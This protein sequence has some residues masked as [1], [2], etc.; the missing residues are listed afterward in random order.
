MGL[1]KH[2][3]QWDGN[4]VWKSSEMKWVSWVRG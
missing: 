3:G 4:G 2:R 1:M